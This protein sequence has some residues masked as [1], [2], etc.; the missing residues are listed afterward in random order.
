[1]FV[2]LRGEIRDGSN[3]NHVKPWE[4]ILETHASSG[5]STGEFPSPSPVCCVSVTMLDMLTPGHLVTGD[6]R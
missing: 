4:T 1:M 3:T 5:W 2:D 6:S